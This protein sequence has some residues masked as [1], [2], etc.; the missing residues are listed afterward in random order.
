MVCCWQY[1]LEFVLFKITPSSLLPVEYL[2]CTISALHINTPTA[3]SSKV[4]QLRPTLPTALFHVFLPDRQRQTK[5]AALSFVLLVLRPLCLACCF[6]SL[7][8]TVLRFSPPPPP[9]PRLAQH[10][11][12]VLASS[13]PRPLFLKNYFRTHLLGHS[14]LVTHTTFLDFQSNDEEC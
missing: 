10:L 11:L 2:C 4:R 12:R 6:S 1:H 8:P 9:L 7:G 14:D 13:G 5:S 3:A